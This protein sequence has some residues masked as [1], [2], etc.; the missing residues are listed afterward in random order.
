MKNAL[1][2]YAANGY[3]NFKDTAI[4]ITK[5]HHMFNRVNVKSADYGIRKR[6]EHRNPIRRETVER[7]TLYIAQFC[8]WLEM[9]KSDC[10]PS[11]GLSSWTFECAVR[12]CNGIIGLSGICLIDIQ[13][14][15]LFC[16]EIY[17]VIIW[18]EDL[19][20]IDSFVEETTIIL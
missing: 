12:T 7:D 17:A 18:K 15:I 19:D 8:T 1:I 10:E 11:N 3:D 9:W 5:I 13:V 6:D 20:G 16:L 2:Y 4:F 14:L